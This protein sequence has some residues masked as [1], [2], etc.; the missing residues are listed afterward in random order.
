MKWFLEAVFPEDIRPVT[1][2]CDLV[3]G[4]WLGLEE[5]KSYHGLI[6]FEG[7]ASFL[8]FNRRRPSTVPD[9]AIP[10]NRRALV[11]AMPD[12]VVQSP[13]VGKVW[14]YKALYVRSIK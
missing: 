10:V 6:Q 14:V 7:P 12:T 4:E 1:V 5:V 13:T 11:V 8:V 9:L 2:T 3:S